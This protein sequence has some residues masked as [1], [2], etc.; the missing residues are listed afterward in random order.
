MLLDNKVALITGAAR[1]LGWGIARAL[2]LAGAKVC[3]TDI[4]DDE[5]ARCARD[6]AADGTEFQVRHSDVAEL[7]DCKRIVQQT[8]DLW[9]RLDVVVVNAI[10][11]PLI[12]TALFSH[13]VAGLS[14]PQKM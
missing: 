9:G 4:N 5:L 13:L 3:V 10:Y 12:T 1:G 6:L 8:V 2:G 14:T 11:M 7:V